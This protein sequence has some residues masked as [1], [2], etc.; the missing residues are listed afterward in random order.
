MDGNIEN[1]KSLQIIRIEK[2]KTLTIFLYYKPYPK[3]DNSKFDSERSIIVFYFDTEHVNQKFLREYLCLAGDIESMS[4]GKYLNKKGCKKKRRVVQFAIITFDKKNSIDEMLDRSSLQLKINT[5]IEKKR[6]GLNF[7]YDPTK[8][9]ELET[10][11]DLD[12][13][14]FVK[15]TPNSNLTLNP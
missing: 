5:L 7:D 2:N 3:K 10:Q 15:V 14:G 11:G 9:K 13:D 1:D 8:L 4:F 6:G 12:L